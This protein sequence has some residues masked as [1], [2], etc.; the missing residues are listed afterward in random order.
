MKYNIA[1]CHGNMAN[2][3]NFR[4]NHNLF[5]DECIAVYIATCWYF[6]ATIASTYVITPVEATSKLSHLSLILCFRSENS[7]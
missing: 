6:L 4:S 7:Q 2:C 5:F 1:T 3:K